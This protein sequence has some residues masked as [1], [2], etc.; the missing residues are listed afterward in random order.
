MKGDIKI[1]TWMLR[2]HYSSH[3][4]WEGTISVEE[5]SNLQ[6]LCV[7]KWVLKVICMFDLPESVVAQGILSTE[8]SC[9]YFPLKLL[10]ADSLTLVRS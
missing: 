5:H 1:T 4:P 2:G 6:G 10:S 8:S 3:L 7:Q 9:L